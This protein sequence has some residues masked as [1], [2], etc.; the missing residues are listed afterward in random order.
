M[1][2]SL[3]FYY[4]LIVL[5]LDILLIVRGLPFVKLRLPGVDAVGLVLHQRLRGPLLVDELLEGQLFL[6]SDNLDVLNVRIASYLVLF[7]VF[8]AEA[9]LAELGLLLPYLDLPIVLVHSFFATAR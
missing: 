1:F 3:A 5:N 8:A 2:D 7:E 4:Y 9:H 6:L